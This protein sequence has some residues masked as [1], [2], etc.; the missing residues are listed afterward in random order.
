[1][2]IV[3]DAG[4]LAHLIQRE[5]ARAGFEAHLAADGLRGL[6]LHA[7]LKPDLII[8]D[9]MLPKL[10]GID[11]LRHIRETATT[12]VI[13]LTA[14]SEEAE[15]V[16]GLDAG[17]DDYVTKPFSTQEL[18]ARTRAL[19][20]RVDMVRRTIEADRSMAQETITRGP[21]RLDPSAHTASVAG[22]R[23]DLTPTEFELLHLMLRNPGRAF[24]RAYL[25]DAIWDAEYVGGDRSVDNAILR[26]RKK[27]GTMADDIETVWGVGYRMRHA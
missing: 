21:L 17:A 25:L 6:E 13:L 22:E 7:S 10:S 8:L 24:S 3:E 1:V 27:L 23:V 26:L 16:M 5:L 2:L 15:R 12:P 4:D 9:W 14:R 11:V 20:R 19:L 18:V